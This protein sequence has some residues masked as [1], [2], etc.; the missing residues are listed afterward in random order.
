MEKI[1]LLIVALLVVSGCFRLTA[2]DLIRSSDG[3][4]Y[5]ISKSQYSGY[6]PYVFEVPCPELMKLSQ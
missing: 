2:T 5:V 3:K 6:Q 1:L 4:C